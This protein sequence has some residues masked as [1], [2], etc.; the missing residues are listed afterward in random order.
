MGNWVPVGGENNGVL[1]SEPPLFVGGPGRPDLG[2]EVLRTIQE[3]ARSLVVIN[4]L[5]SEPAFV[6]ALR[7]ARQR[8]VQVRVITELRENR[9]AGV[10]YPT[11][12]FEYASSN[13]MGTHFTAIRQLAGELVTCRGLRFYA[14]AKLLLADDRTLLISSANG[15]PNSLGR[16]AAP[17]LEAGVRITESEVVTGWATALRQLW[18]AC[19]FRLRAQG[20]DVSLQEEAGEVLAGSELE[21]SSGAFW[22]YPPAHRGL[23]DRLAQLIKGARRRVILGAFT[24]FDTDKIPIM[25]EALQGALARGVEVTV[26]VRPEHFRPIEYPDPS[27]RRL[28]DDGLRL[29]GFTGLHAKGILVDDTACGIFSANINPFSLECDLD[30]ANVEAGLV[31]TAPLCHLGLYAQFLENIVSRAT[32]HYVSC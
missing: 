15:N 31:E 4:P 3:A 25:H 22:S 28:I 10:R 24:F 17:S 27:T 5:V 20:R 21:N 19:P 12:G 29:F 23:R 8:R 30:S 1:V 9:G 13:E 16:G 14:H 7:A 26:V 6:E 11:R 18:D 2:N 32:H